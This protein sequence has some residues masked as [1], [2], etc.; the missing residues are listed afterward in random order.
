MKALILAAGD[1]TRFRK[2]N[3]S[4]NKLLFPVLGM[5][6]IERTIRSAKI[7]GIREFIIV[8]GYQETAVKK[9]LGDGGRFEV[10]IDYVYN[11]RWR[12]ENGTSV[13]AAASKIQEPFVLLMGDHLFEPHVLIRLVRIRLGEKECV[14]AVDTRFEDF[15]KAQESTKA[16]VQKGNVIAI[17]K[18]LKEYNAIDTGMFLCTPYL[19]SMLEKTIKNKKFFLTD[20]MRILAREGRLKAFDIQDGFWADI[21]THKDV[22]IAK[23]QLFTR[24]VQPHGEGPISKHINRRFSHILTRFFL[25]TNVTPNQISIL[26]F[27]LTLLAGFLF[28]ASSYA[29]ILIAGFFTQFASI[30]DGVDGEIAR[31]KLSSSSF[32]AW[33][34]TILDRYGDIAVVTG[35]SISIYR[36][37]QSGIAIIVAVLA[38]TGSIL[39]SYSSYTMKSIFGKSLRRRKHM[40]TLPSGRDIRLFILF[41]G[42]VTNS[43]FPALILI[44]LLTHQ[45]VLFR[46]FLAKTKEERT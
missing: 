18:E 45:S 38:L 14:L 7:A 8:T 25:Q 43:L 23:Q 11:K 26:S 44:A 32:G 20:S 12:G 27:F 22:E 24:L 30:L 28:T 31:V 21:D 42:G 3:N 36:E 6:L 33:F 4:H 39:S 35:A 16:M 41:L 17:G 40:S 19:F 10:Y 5:P 15:M 29:S 34:D 9:F 1:N 13:F 46:L 2:E 37:E